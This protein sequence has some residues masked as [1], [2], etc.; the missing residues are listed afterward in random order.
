MTPAKMEDL[1]GE[2]PLKAKLVREPENTH[3]ENAIAVYLIEKPYTNFQI[4]Y[5]ARVVAS[6]IAPRLDAGMEVVEAWV[7]D[8][9][10]VESKAELQ[11]KVQR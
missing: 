5:L 9:D 7:L 1:A 10:L 2:T 6:E 8:V 11:A 4:G 3:D